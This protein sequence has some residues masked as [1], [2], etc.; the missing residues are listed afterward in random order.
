MRE[1]TRFFVP[2]HQRDFSWTDD[3]IEQLLTDIQDAR[4]A[5][6]PDYFIGLMVFMRKSK[7]ELTILDGQQRLVTAQILLACIRNWLRDQGYSE[8]SEQVQNEYI[9]MRELGKDY[10]D[11][12]LVLNENND[13]TFRDFVIT[14][15]SM[16]EVQNAL[17]ELKRH[18]PNRRLLESVLLCQRKINAL[19]DK[20]KE[21]GLIELVNYLKENVKIVQLVAQ[22]EANAF[23]VFETLNDRGLDLSILDLVKN[24]L[25]G[26]CGQAPDRLREV[27]RNWAQMMANL[28]NVPADDFLK[29]YWTSR[30]GRI[31][32]PQ[33]F[34]SFKAKADNMRKVLDTSADMLATSEEYAAL[35]IA[36]DPIWNGISD[37]SRERIRALKT[38]GAR[39]VHPV[40][41]SALARFSQREF[42]RLLRLLEVLIVRYQLIGGGR[43]GRL[44]IAC[45]SLA[46]VIYQKNVRTAT[47]AFRHV[48]NVFPPDK[49]F[50]EA[51][52]WKQERNNRKVRYILETLEPHAAGGMKAAELAP[53]KSL[54]VEHILPKNPGQ[55]WQAALQL[56]E[57][58]AEE[59]TYRLGNLCLL[60]GVNKDLGAKSFAEKSKVYAKSSL[61]L[62]SMTASYED[63][64]RNSIDKRQE[65]MAKLAVTA[66]RFE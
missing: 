40:M 58:L 18:D 50:R 13:K 47:E 21:T 44:E 2:H 39:Q 56:D 12:R 22:D 24:Y 36:D 3:E 66:W 42:S 4:T 1:G 61:A 20:E 28:S 59:C 16:Q 63:W 32:T 35:E 17:D 60:T 8:D 46:S 43:T 11:S 52:K 57:A 49:E 65:A 25:F 53:V 48:R 10:V 38:L 30:Y 34:R 41:L 26:K 54:T 27:Q 45:A 62:T 9:A 64:N 5:K 55:D 33:L 37:R 31:Q 51:F 15:R 6:Q 23:T 19:A 7:G 14:Q 29:A